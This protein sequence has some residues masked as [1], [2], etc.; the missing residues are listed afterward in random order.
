MKT[1]IFL[2]V[3]ML[4]CI[5]WNVSNGAIY[6]RYLGTLMTAEFVNL[7]AGP[8]DS[9]V[10]HKPAI[11]H[12]NCRWYAPGS[13]TPIFGDTMIVTYTQQ[14]NWMF[15]SA[16]AGNDIYVYFI[17]GLPT[18]PAC[19]THDSVFAQGTTTI[20]WTLDAENLTSGY[21][22]T[23]LWD[24]GTTSKYRTITDAGKYWLRITNDC[25]TRT[26]TIHVSIA[27]VTGQQEYNNKSTFS[28]YPNPSTD[29][30]ILETAAK[31][32]EVEILSLLGQVLLTGHNQKELYISSLQ[33]GTYIVR[34]T[35]NNEIEQRKII[36]Y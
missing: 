29:K 7:C 19:M 31:D 11:S 6:H 33:A 25:G 12:T 5:S 30:V 27:T 26:D 9:L 18:Q 15:S 13:Y 16:E 17:E 4:I 36:V 22:C 34:V 21:S 10:L 35:T 8:N 3:L 24:D 28:C 20:N 2:P 1:K 14:G 32:F 23:Y